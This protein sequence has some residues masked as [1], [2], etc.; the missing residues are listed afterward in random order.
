MG[1]KS[2]VKELK[3]HPWLLHYPWGELEQKR[4]KSP[5]REK[6]HKYEVT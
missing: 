2:G 1:F 6:E 3:A 4:M 5:F